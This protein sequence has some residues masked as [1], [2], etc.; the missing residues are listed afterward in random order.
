MHLGWRE[1][2][3]KLLVAGWLVFANS[4]EVLTIRRR[5]KKPLENASWILRYLRHAIQD[6]SLEVELHHDAQ[7]AGQAG[8][9]SM[10]KFSRTDFAVLDEPSER[11]KGIC[12]V[13]RLRWQRGRSI[14][15][16]AEGA[17]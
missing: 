12:Q 15:A 14:S 3:K 2:L 10:G 4:S 17:L 8:I 13:C 6:G 16:L 7:S 11:R 9:Q 1:R 5:T